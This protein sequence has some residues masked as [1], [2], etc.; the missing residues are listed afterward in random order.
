MGL[1]VE[2]YCSALLQLYGEKRKFLLLGNAKSP[3]GERGG[4]EGHGA[5][6]GLWV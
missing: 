3:H 6:C 4:S 2:G 5:A 1:A